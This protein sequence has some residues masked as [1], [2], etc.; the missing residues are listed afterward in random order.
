MLKKK[1]KD[2][3]DN[4]N[5]NTSFGDNINKKQIAINVY[6]ILIKMLVK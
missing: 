3:S 6:N 5:N 2:N 4:K 1:P